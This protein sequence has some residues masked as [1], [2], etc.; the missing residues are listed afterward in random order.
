MSK[1]TI[2]RLVELVNGASARATAEHLEFLDFLETLVV[3]S[4]PEVSK[5]FGRLSVKAVGPDGKEFAPGIV[6]TPAD[7]L[8]WRTAIIERGVRFSEG[9]AKV[10]SDIFDRMSNLSNI[11]NMTPAERADFVALV[12]AER[13]K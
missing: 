3:A 1:G 7:Y 4:G 12:K 2:L 13:T 6:L 9:V 8:Y 10:K 5:A 11:H